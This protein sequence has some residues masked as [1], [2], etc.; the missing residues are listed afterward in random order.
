MSAER[1]RPGVDL[2]LCGAQ[3]AYTVRLQPQRLRTSLYSIPLQSR[4]LGLGAELLVH[5]WEDSDFCGDIAAQ[6]LALEGEDY[7]RDDDWWKALSLS[8]DTR[9]L[10]L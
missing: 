2:L 9:P 6:I 10:P 4:L 7:H 3:T 5:E 8:I 1:P